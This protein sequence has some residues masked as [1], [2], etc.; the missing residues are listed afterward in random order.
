VF[1][2]AISSAEIETRFPSGFFEGSVVWDRPYCNPRPGRDW[3]RTEIWI[4]GQRETGESNGTKS[5]QTYV[6]RSRENQIG[7][8]TEQQ[9]RGNRRTCK[10]QR[11]GLHANIGVSGAIATEGKAIGRRCGVVGRLIVFLIRNIYQPMSRRLWVRMCRFTPTCSEYAAQAIEKYGV[12]RGGA[13]ACWRILR[14][15]PFVR[16]GEDPV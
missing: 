1:A 2:P 5:R 6:A 10:V 3:R 15:N 7:R 4:F 9:R 16:G 12:F 13:M 8:H 14:C 11:R